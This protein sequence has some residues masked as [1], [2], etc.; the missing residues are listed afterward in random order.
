MG[1]MMLAVIEIY[2]ILRLIYLDWI[3][4]IIFIIPTAFLLYRMWVADTMRQTERIP[5]W[6]QLV[7]YLRRD[8]K[9]IPLIGTRPY[10]GESFID[11]PELGLVEFLGKD[12]VYQWGDKKICWGL[13]NINFTPDPRYFNLTAL[14]YEIGFKDSDDIKNVL[15]GNDLYLMGR[16]YQNMLRWDDNHGAKKLVTELKTYDGDKVFFKPKPKPKIEEIHNKIDKI[17]QARIKI[18]NR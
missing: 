7:N 9:V 10:S 8:N 11:I 18:K 1:Y 12:T 5:R 2:P 13:E 14:F 6:R 17:K 16:V 4:T 15:L 3:T